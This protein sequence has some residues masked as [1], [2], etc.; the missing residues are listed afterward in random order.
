MSFMT[1]MLTIL[2]IAMASEVP[3]QR[4]LYEEWLDEM[5]LED[6]QDENDWDDSRVPSPA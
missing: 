4:M 1:V 6:E 3:Q 5:E 2:I